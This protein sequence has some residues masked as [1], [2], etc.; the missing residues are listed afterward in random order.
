LEIAVASGDSTEP[1]GMSRSTSAPAPMTQRAPM[2]TGSS[3]VAFTPMKLAWP[4]RTPPEITTREATNTS[5]S[6]T[7]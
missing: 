6:I 3:S 2:V 7:E 5:S 4:I 1:S